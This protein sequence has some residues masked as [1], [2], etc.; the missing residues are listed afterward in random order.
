VNTD[1]TTDEVGEEPHPDAMADNSE[2]S[3]DNDKRSDT[4][5]EG[6]SQ[7]WGPEN[8]LGRRTAIIGREYVATRT[9]FFD[10]FCASATEDGIGQLVILASGLD[11]RAYRLSCL[12][13]V[14]VYEID[15]RQYKSS[16]NRLSA[17]TA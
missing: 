9:V 13:G 11:A 7:S 2:S 6:V 8:E 17:R 3:N 15:S 10:E 4:A 16:S 12:S 14:D 1:A 5:T